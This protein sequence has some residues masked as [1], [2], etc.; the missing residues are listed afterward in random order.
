MAK[1]QAP[2]KKNPP[3]KDAAAVDPTAMASTTIVTDDTPTAAATDATG[4]DR[5]TPVHLE[6][7]GIVTDR[8][9]IA[10]HPGYCTRHIDCRLTPRQ[11]ATAKM[12]ANV[13]ANRGERR[14]GGRSSHPAGTVVDIAADSICWLLD[15]AAD[16]LEQVTGKSLVDD[17]DLSFR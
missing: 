8:A 1:T 15:R 17:F 16:E 11:A 10:V 4:E 7:L 9:A 12:L 13:L 6:R 2:T 3:K 14:E 5:S